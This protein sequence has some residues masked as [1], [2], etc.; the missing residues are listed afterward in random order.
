MG[1]IFNC[2]TN[3]WSL[4]FYLFYIPLPF[5]FYLNMIICQIILCFWIELT[6]QNECSGKDR[7]NRGRSMFPF[8][9]TCPYSLNTLV[10]FTSFF[11]IQFKVFAGIFSY[12]RFPL[13]LLSQVFFLVTI[14]YS[15][16]IT[17]W[18]ALK[19]TK[20][21]QNISAFWKHVLQS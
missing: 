9:I 18:P 5:L 17:R 15:W 4:I 20:P 1:Q 19:R 13:L 7:G 8:P 2:L 21:L 3:F 10:A 16:N 12:C 6:R 11:S 14:Y